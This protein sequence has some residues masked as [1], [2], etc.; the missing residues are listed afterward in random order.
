[1][2]DADGGIFV[3]TDGGLFFV[4]VDGTVD[5]RTVPTSS[6]A[7]T[8]IAASAGRL[9]AGTECAGVFRSD[10]GG[11]TWQT[12]NVGLIALGTTSAA[13]D[14]SGASGARYYALTECGIARML[15]SGTWEPWGVDP[16]LLVQEDESADDLDSLQV[17]SD[18]VVYAVGAATVYR[19]APGANWEILVRVA[20]GSPDYEGI[21][22]FLADSSTHRVSLYFARRGEVFVS[23]NH[24]Q[25]WEVEARPGGPVSDL[26]AWPGPKGVRVVAIVEEK[27]LAAIGGGLR[28][29][30][31]RTAPVF[32]A[33]ELTVVVANPV[34]GTLIAS[35]SALLFE[36]RKRGRHWRHFDQGLPD[37]TDGTW[38]YLAIDPTT[39]PATLYAAT[40]S[41]SFLY[42]RPEVAK[43]KWVRATEYVG[44]DYFLNQLLVDPRTTPGR[45]LAVTEG[46]GLFAL[47]P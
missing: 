11:R 8:S 18:G 7:L 42:R 2:A 25:T 17:D 21:D 30:N 32:D 9:F 10:D 43:G 41:L 16:E 46:A 40:P 38:S 13:V 6:A 27:G 23:H 26:V 15:E 44:P 39:D 47:D 28:W 4:G 19:R 45:L 14:S 20:Y 31:R 22:A 33:T 3:R 24:G 1:M 35:D 36:G 12:G 5:A 37:D 29:L 34:T